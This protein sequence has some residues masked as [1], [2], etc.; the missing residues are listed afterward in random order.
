M[1]RIEPQKPDQTFIRSR[2]LQRAV[3]A[4]LKEHGPQ[5]YDV[6]CVHFDPNRSAEIEAIFREL[7]QWKFVEKGTDLRMMVS[8]TASGIARLGLKDI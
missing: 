2:E 6:L 3:L 7:I 8:I 1:A 4:Y 5:P